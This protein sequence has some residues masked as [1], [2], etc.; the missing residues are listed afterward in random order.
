MQKVQDM[1][2]VEIIGSMH[3]FSANWWNR[4]QRTTSHICLM[5]TAKII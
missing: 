4:L 2:I 1:K 3:S 5:Y